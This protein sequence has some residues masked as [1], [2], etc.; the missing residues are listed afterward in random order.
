MTVAFSDTSLLC[1][2]LRPLPSFS[3]KVA[4]A[5]KE[6]HPAAGRL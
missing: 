6:Q 5:G 2:M 4:T 1:D 3:N